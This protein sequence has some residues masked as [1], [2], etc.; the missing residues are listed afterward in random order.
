MDETAKV[1]LAA[2]MNARI[3]FGMAATAAERARDALGDVDAS[4]TD[5]LADL[6][7]VLPKMERVLDEVENRLIAEAVLDA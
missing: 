2:S 6:A 4:V 7:D 5:A 3:V 1:A